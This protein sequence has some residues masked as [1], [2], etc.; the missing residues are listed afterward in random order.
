[1]T[2]DQ[3]AK[4]GSEHG[5][6]AAVFAWAAIAAFHGFEYAWR[7]ANEGPKGLEG[8]PKVGVECLRW[9][10]AI[11]NGGS[12][13]DDEKSRAIRGAQLKAEGVKD[14]VS[15]IFLPQPVGV[16]H[17]L[18]IEMK[19]PTGTVRPSQKEFGEFVGRRGYGFAICRSWREACEILQQ[20]LEHE[21]AKT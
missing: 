2:P 15:D 20:Y 9:L 17:G 18:Y 21:K 10:H 8:S 1:M 7:F 14:G 19:T 6:Q 5:I 12:R 3:L 16:Y 11:P 13:G 4:S